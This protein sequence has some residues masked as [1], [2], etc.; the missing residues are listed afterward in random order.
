MVVPQLVLTFGRVNTSLLLNLWNSLNILKLDLKVKACLSNSLM[1]SHN[2]Y[3]WKS[4]FYQLFLPNGTWSVTILMTSAPTQCQPY[5]HITQDPTTHPS[6]TATL[7]QGIGPRPL[8][9]QT[10]LLFWVVWAPGIPLRSAYY[11]F[12]LLPILVFCQTSHSPSLYFN[13][14]KGSCIIA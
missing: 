1:R 4:T 10:P 6:P 9:F 12:G 7:T 2:P 8:L 3:P 5:I 14:Y 13:V 11:Q